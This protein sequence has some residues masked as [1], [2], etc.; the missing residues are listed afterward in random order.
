M[1]QR[2]TVTFKPPG[3]I[4]RTIGFLMALAMTLGG[5]SWVFIQVLVSER[6]FL[7][8]MI[9][10]GALTALGAYWLWIDYINPTAEPE[11]ERGLGVPEAYASQGRSQQGRNSG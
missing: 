8:L 1:L 11:H 6:V 9:G 4:R 5:A 7:K 3:H 10:A 2:T